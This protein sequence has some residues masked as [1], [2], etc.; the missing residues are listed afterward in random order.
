MKPLFNNAE[1]G[2]ENVTSTAATKCRNAK[3]RTAKFFDNN[4]TSHSTRY[5]K[6]SAQYVFCIVRCGKRC[7][8]LELEK[9][10]NVNEYKY[11]PRNP[12]VGDY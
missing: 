11:S 5:L 9:A 8:D 4:V 3:Q 10:C 12:S 2:V 7:F 1:V 6:N